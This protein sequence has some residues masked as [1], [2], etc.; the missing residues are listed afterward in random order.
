MARVVGWGVMYVKG[1]LRLD[2]DLGSF[3]TRLAGA[4]RFAAGNQWLLKPP[5]NPRRER[6]PRLFRK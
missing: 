6:G 4:G 2:C 5:A 3:T 1:A